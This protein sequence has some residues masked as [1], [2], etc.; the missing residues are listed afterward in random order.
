MFGLFKK[1]LTFGSP[2]ERMRHEMKDKIETLAYTLYNEHPMK[3]TDLGGMFFVSGINTARDNFLKRSILISKV[4][5][6][7]RETGIQIIN[8]CAK[9]V[10]S[11]NVD[12]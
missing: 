8:D 3:G 1:K 2:E 9:L 4:Y 6:V 10:Y 7:T 11:E 12:S 5:G